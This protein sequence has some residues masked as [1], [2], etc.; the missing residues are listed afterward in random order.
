M[1][2]NLG[3]KDKARGKRVYGNHRIVTTRVVTVIGL[4]FMLDCTEGVVDTCGK[5]VPLTVEGTIRVV[6]SLVM[7]WDTVISLVHLRDLR[8]GAWSSRQI[9][10]SCARGKV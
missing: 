10:V 3:S 5:L 2:R 1:Y 8:L 4:G 7:K 9:R 6:G